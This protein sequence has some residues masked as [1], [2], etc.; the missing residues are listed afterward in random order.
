M[1]QL[2]VYIMTA[3]RSIIGMLTHKNGIAGTQHIKHI[4][5]VI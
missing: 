2:L 5:R 4:Y 1:T 3:I